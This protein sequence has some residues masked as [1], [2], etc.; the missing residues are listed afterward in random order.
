MAI[1]AFEK[2]PNTA[3]FTDGFKNAKDI[4][5]GKVGIYF[6]DKAFSSSRQ[7][8]LTIGHELYHAQQFAYLG[9]IGASYT[10]GLSI[11]MDKGAYLWQQSIG[12]HVLYEFTEA[13]NAS[14]KYFINHRGNIDLF[15]LQNGFGSGLP[16][17]IPFFGTLKPP[18]S[19]W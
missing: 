15:I 17:I 5:T 7:L 10:R 2:N 1:K 9:S 14:Y 18:V 6:S 3:G 4:Y 16:K 11:A 13:E 8:F 12:D 19:P